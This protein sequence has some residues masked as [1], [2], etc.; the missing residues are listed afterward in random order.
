MKRFKRGKI[1]FIQNIPVC[2][3]EMYKGRYKVYHE[4]KEC[5]FLTDELESKKRLKELK[6]G[7]F[8]YVYGQRVKF[9][10]VYRYKGIAKFKIEL[11]NKKIYLAESLSKTKRGKKMYCEEYYNE[12]KSI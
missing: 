7:T 12:I 11:P 10:G 3:V 8:V 1:Y 5:Y 9:L 4:K 6:A 2:F